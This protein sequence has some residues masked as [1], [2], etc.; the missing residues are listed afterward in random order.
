M[1]WKV[2]VGSGGDK[3]VVGSGV[4][5]DAGGGERGCWEVVVRDVRS[6]GWWR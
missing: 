5:G 1:W 3:G 2:V 6:R 4:R